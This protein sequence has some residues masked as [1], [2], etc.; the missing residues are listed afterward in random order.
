MSTT[1]QSRTVRRLSVFLSFLLAF[2]VMTMLPTPAYAEEEYV[3]MIGDVGYTDI[4]EA[5][6]RANDWDT[7]KLV[8]DVEKTTSVE[9]MEDLSNGHLAIYSAAIFING[10]SLT[11]DTNGYVF[12]VGKQI[13]IDKG[14]SATYNPPMWTYGLRVINGG[15]L[16]LIDSSVER[17]GQFNISGYC[18]VSVFGSGSKATV[19]NTI[20]FSTY[21]QHSYSG[22]FAADGGIITILGDVRGGKS[23][24]ARAINGGVISIEG[25]VISDADTTLYAAEKDSSIVVYG[26][27]VNTVTGNSANF[28][29]TAEEGA[30]IKVNGSVRSD[31]SH[32][33]IADGENTT[34][35]I[36]GNLTADQ[37]TGVQAVDGAKVTI[38]GVLTAS[39]YVKLGTS[40]DKTML[41]EKES[42][43]ISQSNP[44]YYEYSDSVN[45]VYVKSDGSI[46]N[47]KVGA[48][49]SGDLF[50]RGTVTM[51][52]SLLAARAVIGIGMNLSIEQFA[53]FDMDLDGAL[54]MIDVT[55]ILQKACGL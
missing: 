18:A 36:K 24:A 41:Y 8:T 32:G 19:S 22:V 7:I 50:G 48:P 46:I 17:T 51:D 37:G 15:E 43:V 31:S 29:I 30:S 9:I 1:N 39:N 45:H 5:I 25:S 21:A 16:N 11:V 20:A 10:R 3:C 55:L 42:A 49:G 40:S 44:G 34:V 38:D 28:V 6:K 12:S 33:V 13:Q 2:G 27:V 4:D 53:A 14:L 47:T 52:V 35:E 26:D 54:T 23:S